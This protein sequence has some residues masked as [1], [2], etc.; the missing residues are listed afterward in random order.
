MDEAP[1]SVLA[2]RVKMKQA[3]ARS[4]SIPPECE[5][6]SGGCRGKK[7]EGWREDAEKA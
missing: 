5:E 6:R 1:A 4:I 7:Q 3:E 2:T